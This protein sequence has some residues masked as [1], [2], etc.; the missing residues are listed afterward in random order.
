MNCCINVNK[1]LNPMASSKPHS[2]LDIC[3]GLL[4]D[5]SNNKFL[6]AYSG[7]LDSS[8]LL[9]CFYKLSIDN[10]IQ[11]RSI[12]INH[13]LSDSADAY[14]KHCKVI[15][16]EYGINHISEKIKVN[17]KSNIEEQCRIERYKKI[18]NYCMK[19]E[20]IITAHHQEDQV[21]TFFLRL[22][23]GS[24]VRGL[25][26]MKNITLINDRKIFRPF[27]QITKDQIDDYQI[28]HN[29]K[30][31]RDETNNESKFDRNYIRN[32]ILPYLKSRWPSLNKNILNNIQIQ[33]IQSN[34]TID[35]I[36][37]ILP[38]FYGNSKNELSINKLNQEQYHT[39]V[40]IIHEWVYLREKITLNLK[41][42]NEIVKILNTNNDSNP[43]FKFAD[44]EIKKE[45][46]ILSLSGSISG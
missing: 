4:K 21:E 13:G 18:T 11:I 45:R 7:G 15:S 10:P 20:I 3:N 35:N 22:I 41:Q 2:L 39:K 14:E 28:N 17:S 44:V 23:R 5:L 1:K 36:E 25:S 42:I 32:N 29:I 24:G 34:F 6:I 12:H 38:N 43:L 26:C 33:D 8:V 46:D 27:L 30:Y 9:D 31:I 16:E 19:D 37:K 40:V